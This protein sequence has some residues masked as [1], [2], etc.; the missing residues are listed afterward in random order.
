[1]H[2]KDSYHITLRLRAHEKSLLEFAAWESHL[3]LE[4]FVSQAAMRAAQESALQQ[5]QV[6][7]TVSEAQKY[8]EALDR[9]FVPNPH[10][11]KAIELA[12]RVEK[13]GHLS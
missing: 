12:D 3:S 10:L 4:D 2:K 5:R 8:I 6:L 13:E 1:M 9:P 11:K 7:F